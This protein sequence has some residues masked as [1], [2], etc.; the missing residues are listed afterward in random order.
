V[1]FI[2][3][4]LGKTWSKIYAIGS[5]FLL[6]FVS[7]IYYILMVSIIFSVISSI[8]LINN[9]TVISCWI[10]KD[11]G[12]PNEIVLNKFSYTY[13]CIISTFIC[14]ILV[15]IKDLLHIIKYQFQLTN[16]RIS[17]Y[18]FIAIISYHFFLMYIFI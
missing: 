6:C 3:K 8:L 10:Y 11:I 13:V 4:I 2:I 18:G 14:A 1:V 5:G 7:I 15:S 17:S 9:I 16:F 12:S